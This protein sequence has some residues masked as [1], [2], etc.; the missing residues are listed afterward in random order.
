MENDVL[1]QA[2]EVA[3]MELS[4]AMNADENGHRRALESVDS[5]PSPVQRSPPSLR[6][7]V[8]GVMH[9]ESFQ[10]EVVNDA[11]SRPSLDVSPLEQGNHLTSDPTAANH[12]LSPY[13]QGTTRSPGGEAAVTVAGAGTGTAIEQIKTLIELYRLSREQLLSIYDEYVSEK[14]QHEAQLTI[15]MAHAQAQAA[16]M[17][18]SSS[19]VVEG[20]GRV[21]VMN[22]DVHNSSPDHTETHVHV[23]E[24]PDCMSSHVDVIDVATNAVPMDEMDSAGTG[25]SEYEGRVGEG[26]GEE[27]STAT[28]PATLTVNGGEEED[29]SESSHVGKMQSLVRSALESYETASPVGSEI[30]QKRKHFTLEEELRLQPSPFAQ[31]L[32]E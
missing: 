27:T 25:D 31:Q 23:Q 21:H 32:L 8:H 22:S 4:G 7:P 6:S 14:S 30:G 1:A 26:E 5:S 9:H 12:S 10:Q 28:T 18:N 2:S 16:A 17:L 24:H 15:S 29:E 20:G 13:Q 11:H 3:V 19:L